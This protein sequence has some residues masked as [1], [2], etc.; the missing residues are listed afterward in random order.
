MALDLNMQP[1]FVSG[2][3][4]WGASAYLSS[5]FILFLPN[6]I[7]S[8]SFLLSRAEVE[9]SKAIGRLWWECLTTLCLRTGS[10]CY[11]SLLLKFLLFLSTISFLAGVKAKDYRN[12]KLKGKATQEKKKRLLFSKNRKKW[13]T[14]ENHP[15]VPRYLLIKSPEIKD[16]YGGLN[17][18]SREEE[19]QE[20]RVLLHGL[21]EV[22]HGW[23][24][25]EG[26]VISFLHVLLSPSRQ[27]SVLKDAMHAL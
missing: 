19:R 15:I 2:N 14:E 13:R 25:E 7:L 8:Y 3:L 11:I 18:R 22:L 10:L 17:H 26:T 21:L 5:S 4:S 16:E 1:F 9:L 27:Q 20:G 24:I 12:I 23:V 6:P